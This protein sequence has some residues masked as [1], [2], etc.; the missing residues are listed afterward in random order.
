MDSRGF[1]RQDPR[2]ASELLA[3]EDP[4]WDELHALMDSPHARGDREA[5]LLPR[6]LVGQ[7]TDRRHCLLGTRRP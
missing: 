5:R 1:E 4:E 2:T 6:G 7:G 3:A